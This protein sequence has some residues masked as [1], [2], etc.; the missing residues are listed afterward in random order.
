MWVHLSLS[1]FLYIQKSN[2]NHNT[3]SSQVSQKAIIV[4][5][6]HMTEQHV[7]LFLTTANLHRGLNINTQMA[8]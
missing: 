1:T 4:S 6:G 3:N 5:L 8:L 7:N 2:K